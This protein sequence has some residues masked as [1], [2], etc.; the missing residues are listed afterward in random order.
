MTAAKQQPPEDLDLFERA[1]GPPALIPARRRS[2]RRAAL[3]RLPQPRKPLSSIRTRSSIC[4][5]GTGA[6]GRVFR[7]L[8]AS[9]GA[10]R[11]KLTSRQGTGTDAI[12]PDSTR[13]W[14][15][16]DAVSGRLREQG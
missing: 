9:S 5:V 3:P 8:Q 2:L 11:G 14:S 15:H 10:I 1:P 16:D 13:A 7:V 4:P 12:V 6:R